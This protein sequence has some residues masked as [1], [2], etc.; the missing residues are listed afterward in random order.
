MPDWLNQTDVPVKVK[1]R[2]TSEEDIQ[3]LESAKNGN[4]IE[5]GLKELAE[6]SPR[7][8]KSLT[9]RYYNLKKKESNKSIVK[10]PKLKLVKKLPPV[11]A[12]ISI[13]GV[14]IT[15]P[16]NHV[17]INGTKIEW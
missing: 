7:S 6:T 2:Y 1:R 4:S 13:A 3:I 10:E 16:S 8:W 5:A 17:T 11:G 9:Q 15:V 12:T 14:I